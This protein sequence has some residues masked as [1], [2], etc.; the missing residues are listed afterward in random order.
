M[1]ID[2]LINIGIYLVTCGVIIVAATELIFNK[3]KED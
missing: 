1:D 2:H 3:S